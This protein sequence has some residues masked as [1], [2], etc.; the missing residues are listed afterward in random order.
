MDEKQLKKMTLVSE[1]VA[2]VYKDH[3]SQFALHDSDGIYYPRV[4]FKNK[5]DQAF[6]LTFMMKDTWV[7]IKRKVEKL[8]ESDGICVV[9][10]EKEKYRISPK[11]DYPKCDTTYCPHCCELTCVSCIRTMKGNDCPVCRKDME[12]V[13]NHYK[14]EGT[15]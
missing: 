14:L 6:A 12:E 8:I 11:V 10:F 4:I 13:F 1:L 5:L 15:K 2:N 7:D 9:C 3:I